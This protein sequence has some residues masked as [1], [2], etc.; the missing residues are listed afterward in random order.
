MAGSIASELATTSAEGEEAFIGALFQSLGRM[1]AQFYFPEEAANIRTLVSAPQ[2][3]L[4][5]HAAAS[6]V[7]GIS[8]E[9]LG[10]GVAKAWGLPEGIQRCM[11]VPTGAPPGRVPV[12]APERLRWT[13]RA[14]NVMADA[15]LHA[16]P[17]HVDA[18][19]DQAAR[20]FGK[21]LGLNPAQVQRATTV[22]RKKLVEL[23]QA[24]EIKV[25]HSSRAALLLQTPQDA[26]APFSAA[27]ASQGDMLAGSV[28]EATQTASAATPN[29]ATTTPGHV[30]E[31]LAAGIQDITNVM[32][33]DFKLSDV[34]RMILEAMFRA[35][36][37]HRIIFCMRDPKTDTL[38]GR[39]GLGAGVEGVVKSFCVPLNAPGAPDLFATI[40]AKGADTLI[41]DASDPRLSERLP[42]WYRKVF[43]APTFLILPLLI[44]GKPFGLIYADKADP[45]GLKIDEK[46]LA[47]LRTLRNQAVMAFK[48]SS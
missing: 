42:P 7:L 37:F 9:A 29:R 11:Q 32:V 1:L 8:Y 30:A 48:Q 45:H 31:T 40:C 18:H 4:S 5:E 10:M 33:E 34:L 43:N 26:T 24:M 15:M 46:E 2:E 19:L 16:D 14:A 41:S 35:L 6:R 3:A 44:K 25:P 20:Q 36:D 47:L 27:A 39:F 38:T 28:L 23:A 13:A 22:A 21:T 12:D 17:N